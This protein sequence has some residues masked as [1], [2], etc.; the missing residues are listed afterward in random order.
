MKGEPAGPGG[1]EGGVNL[2]SRGVA[3]LAGL[4][5]GAGLL[6][7][8]M[9]RPE[10]VI[11]FLDVAG[12]WDGSLAFVMIGAIGVF[13]MAAYRARHTAAPVW[14]AA[15]QWPTRTHLDVPLVL[16]SAIFG[17]GWGIAGYCPGPA[18][19][20]VGAGNLP[21]AWFTGAMAVGMVIYRFARR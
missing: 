13:A 12:D 1:P 21:A 15:F 17:V 7:S 4:L 8:G 14:A 6:I 2:E 19:V 20:A 5:F 18:L 11:G 9:T 10:K 3:L 16:G